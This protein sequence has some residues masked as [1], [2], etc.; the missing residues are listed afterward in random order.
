M[1]M[2]VMMTLGHLVVIRRQ[3]PCVLIMVFLLL[4]HIYWQDD[5]GDV[6]T[7]PAAP[8]VPKEDHKTE[9]E[10]SN[11]PASSGYTK[12]QIKQAPSQIG[13]VQIQTCSCIVTCMQR[14][15]FGNAPSQSL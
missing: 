14:W 15:H 10:S 1:K 5:A 11:S 13:N 6:T 7:V 4:L 3:V 8:V 2:K 9:A 12:K